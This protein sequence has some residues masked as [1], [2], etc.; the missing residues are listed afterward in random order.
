LVQ[1]KKFSY[2]AGAPKT[3]VSVSE[4]SPTIDVVVENEKNR[5]ISEIAKVA[6]VLGSTPQ[7]DSLFTAAIK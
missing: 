6:K 1:I 2:K 4:L 7:I 3:V 5:I